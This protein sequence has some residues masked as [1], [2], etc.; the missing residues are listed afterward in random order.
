MIKHSSLTFKRKKMIKNWQ[1][2]CALLFFPPVCFF[3]CLSIFY[4]AIM[5]RKKTERLWWEFRPP[6]EVFRVDNVKNDTFGGRGKRSVLYNNAFVTRQCLDWLMIVSFLSSSSPF[7]L[8][9]L[10][11]IRTKAI[12]QAP[13]YVIIAS[14]CA[15]CVCVCPCVCVSGR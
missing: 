6:G 13:C 14:L 1:P 2:S 3:V 11:R 7:S 5:R 9:D 15:L 10:I 8:I 4:V 12:Q